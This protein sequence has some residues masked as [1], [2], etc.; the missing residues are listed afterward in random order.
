MYSNERERLL[1]L[2]AD[3][4]DAPDSEKLQLIIELL[5]ELIWSGRWD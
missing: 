3:L 5:R 1:S 2:L 4:E